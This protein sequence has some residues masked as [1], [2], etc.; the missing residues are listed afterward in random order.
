MEKLISYIIV[1]LAN[2]CIYSLVAIGFVVIY[3]SSGI[4][5]FSHGAIVLLSAYIFYLF[6]FQFGLPSRGHCAHLAL[7]LLGLALSVCLDRLIGPS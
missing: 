2:G 1:G 4:I 6:S 7:A 3:K 5:N